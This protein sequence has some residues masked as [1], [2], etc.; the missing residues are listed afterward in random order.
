MYNLPSNVSKDGQWAYPFQNVGVEEA[1]FVRVTKY[2]QY[3]SNNL[4][5]SVPTST[6]NDTNAQTLYRL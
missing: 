2:L 5:L 1:Y 6:N 3:I 4:E